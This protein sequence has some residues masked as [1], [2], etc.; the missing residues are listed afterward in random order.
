MKLSL[1]DYQDNSAVSTYK[2]PRSNDWQEMN[3][4]SSGL[5][6]LVHFIDQSGLQ[7]ARIAKERPTM[8]RHQNHRGIRLAFAS[9][10]LAQDECL[11]KRFHTYLLCFFTHLTWTR[12]MHQERQ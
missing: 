2:F 9:L 3:E 8:P 10:H 1:G 11:V 6:P 7:I 4:T 12:Q 5:Q